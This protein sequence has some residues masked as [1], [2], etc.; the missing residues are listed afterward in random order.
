MLGDVLVDLKGFEPLTSSMPWKRA[1]NCATG[2]QT[3]GYEMRITY[4]VPELAPR[5]PAS[6]T[7]KFSNATLLTKDPIEVKI[8]RLPKHPQF[9]AAVEPQG[10]HSN[11]AVRLQTY[12]ALFRHSYAE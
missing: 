2:P 10:A 8:R 5:L 4:A 9:P 6:S 3:K 11:E 7:D 12:F 1:P